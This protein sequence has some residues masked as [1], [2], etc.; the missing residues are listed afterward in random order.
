MA[1]RKPKDTDQNFSPFVAGME[2]LNFCDVLETAAVLEGLPGGAYCRI[3]EDWRSEMTPNVQRLAFHTSG[4]VIRF[5]TDSPRIGLRV[6]LTS[7]EDMPH[8]PRTGSSGTDIYLGSGTERRYVNTLKPLFNDDYYEGATLLPGGVTEVTIYLPLYNGVRRLEIGVEPGAS[9]QSP[10]P[11]ICA[12]PIVFYGSSITQGGCACRTSTDYPAVVCR[13]LDAGLINLGF[14]GSALGE[15]PLAEFIASLEMGCLVYDY[16]NNAPDSEHLRKTHLPF[17]QSFLERR[18]EVPVV[19]LSK[20]NFNSE[21]PDD[22]VRRRIVYASFRWAEDNGY[23]AAFVDGSTLFGKD[24]EL[25]TVD[26]LHPN[27]LGFYFMGKAVTDTVRRLLE[28]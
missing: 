12:A 27:D 10:G 3:P 20:T 14:S 13:R 17:I 24:T 15:L 8:M 7:G 1:D 26:S 25:C 21:D 9:V 23:R 22:S 5:L 18:P 2:G 4:G 28:R 16:D 6:H 11:H 19:F